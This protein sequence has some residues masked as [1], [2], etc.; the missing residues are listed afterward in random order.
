MK[1]EMPRLITDEMIDTFALRSRWEELPRQV[2]E[3]Y[4]GLLD[5]V[6][7]YFP[8]LTRSKR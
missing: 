3:K 8:Y 7:Y 1:I 5:R 6:S 4:S 2:L